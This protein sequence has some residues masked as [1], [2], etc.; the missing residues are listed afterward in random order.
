LGKRIMNK[1]DLEKGIYTQTAM[2][3]TSYACFRVLEER[4]LQRCVDL[5]VFFWQATA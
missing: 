4:C 5:N 1:G 2:L 3:T